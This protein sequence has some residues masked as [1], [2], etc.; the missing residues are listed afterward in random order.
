MQ[1]VCAIEAPFDYLYKIACHHY[2]CVYNYALLCIDYLCMSVQVCL[3]QW[4]ISVEADREGPDVSQSKWLDWLYFSV[5]GHAN[6]VQCSVQGSASASFICTNL[7]QF[8]Y[9]VLYVHF[10]LFTVV[11]LPRMPTELVTVAMRTSLP[12][13]WQWSRYSFRLISTSPTSTC[14]CRTNDI[15]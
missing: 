10:Q 13:D 14:E 9:I 2:Y 8:N 12:V 4:Y 11:N 6:Q 15:Q 3:A 7:K 5:I 1:W